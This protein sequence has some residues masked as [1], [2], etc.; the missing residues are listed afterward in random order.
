MA[1]LALA[2]CM[3]PLP[4]KG[5]YVEPKLVVNCIAVPDEPIKAVVYKSD[6]IFDTV[7]DYTMPDGTQVFLYVNG[8]S[9]GE[10]QHRTDTA[11]SNYGDF[12]SVTHYF[13]HDYI[14]QIGDVVKLKV[15]AP[16]FDE[17]EGNSEPLPNEPIG[18]IADSRVTEWD[19]TSM[20]G[21]RVPVPDT[22]T[23]DIMWY[24]EYRKH[25]TVTLEVTDPNPGVL[26]YYCL[27]V[28]MRLEGDWT[29]PDGREMDDNVGRLERI[30]FNDPIIGTSTAELE[31]Q[32][33]LNL[34]LGT[35]SKSTFNDAT[36]DGGSYYLSLPMVTNTL[37]KANDSI[38]AFVDIK[39]RHLTEG[40]YN[41]FGTVT[42][43]NAYSQYYSEP[44]SVYSN[45]ENGFG[46]VAGSNDKVISFPVW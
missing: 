11:F 26:D 6:Y 28:T 34:G 21:F 35:R 2:A 5:E 29:Y 8:E 37:F 41:Y 43:S 1:V 18:R 23:F 45:V 13:T 44:V 38:N 39:L 24:T 25:I 3:K 17:V 30:Y 14:P 32:Y 40:A 27:E 33:G 42:S 46:L 22:D 31:D 12:Y 9:K 16:G 19:T 36:F 20:I 15:T 7:T 4:F 10:M